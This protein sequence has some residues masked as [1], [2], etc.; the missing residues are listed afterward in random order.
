MHINDIVDMI[1]ECIEEIKDTPEDY[2]HH[3][4]TLVNK[5]DYYD[6]YNDLKEKMLEKLKGVKQ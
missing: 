6:G 2:T 1:D 3:D 4:G 5:Y